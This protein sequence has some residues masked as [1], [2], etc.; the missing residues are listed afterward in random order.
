[1][2]LDRNESTAGNGVVAAAVTG[3]R[4]VP[5]AAGHVSGAA[6]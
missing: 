3:T 6:R 2:R 5:V 4:R 1:V